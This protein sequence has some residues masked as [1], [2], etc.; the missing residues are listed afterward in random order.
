M[1]RRFARGKRGSVDGQGGM[2]KASGQRQGQYMRVT[3]T[4]LRVLPLLWGV[5]CLRG[6]SK[7]TT[8]KL[9]ACKDFAILVEG[10]C[11]AQRRTSDPPYSP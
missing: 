8:R 7:T 6:G 3:P 11:P 9:S 10:R 4:H 2:D 5:V 1:D